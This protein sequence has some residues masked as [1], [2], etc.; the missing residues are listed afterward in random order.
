MRFSGAERFGSIND[1]L[2]ER[3][4]RSCGI[5]SSGAVPGQAGCSRPGAHTSPMRRTE[6]GLPS[7][8][9]DTECRLAGETRWTRVARR[10]RRMPAVR[11]A[12][13]RDRERA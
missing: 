12:P 11:A 3:I 8:R 1:G 5:A 4:L 6:P 7:N 2:A 13:G 10:A 9:S